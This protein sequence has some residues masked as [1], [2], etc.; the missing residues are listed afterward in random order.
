MTV[1]KPQDRLQPS[2]LERLKDDEPNK[3]Q[4]T[5]ER[6][7]LSTSA[8]RESVRR[9]LEWLLNTGK[10][11]VTQDLARYPR[12]AK[13]VLN[14]GFRDLAGRTLS[15]ARSEQLEEEVWQA[16]T[17]FEPRILRHTLQVRVKTDRQS[18]EHNALA[19]EIEGELW[20]EP[21]PEHLLLKAHVDLE[22]GNVV[23]QGSEGR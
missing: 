22:N 4:E 19:F 16:I 23:V 9:D 21:M 5:R 12:V 20:A 8:F 6:R 14:F 18:T 3:R 11:D 10:L 7:V 13:S 15:S 2:L 1:L 17:S